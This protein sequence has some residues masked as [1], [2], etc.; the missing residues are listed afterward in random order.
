MAVET[1][2]GGVVSG[3]PPSAT[4]VTVIAMACAAAM[5]SPSLA[6]TVMS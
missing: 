2:V 6:V 4:L 3:P 1:T 5:F